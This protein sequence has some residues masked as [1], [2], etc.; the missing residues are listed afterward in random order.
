MS[1][2]TTL[3]SCGDTPHFGNKSLCNSCRWAGIIE[4]P[5]FKDRVVFCRGMGN[6]VEPQIRFPVLACNGYQ[7]IGSL[8]K[9]EMES[10]ALIIDPDRVRV[11]GFAPKKD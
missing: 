8:T 4:G 6:T 2:E 11:Q 9:P 1:E 10:V 7:K 3:K 5:R